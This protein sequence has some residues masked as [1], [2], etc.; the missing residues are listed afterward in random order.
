MEEFKGQ[1]TCLGGNT[2]KYIIFSVPIGKELLELINKEE[3][4]QKPY[5]KDY[6]LL[7]VPDLW[8][9]YYQTL[10]TILLSEFIKLNANTDTMITIVKLAE[11]STKITTPFLNIQTLKMI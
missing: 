10:L 1:F 6:N 9:V 8:Q 7:T 11:L 3:I 2:E 5:L 4:S